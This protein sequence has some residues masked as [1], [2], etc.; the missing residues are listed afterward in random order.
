MI[1]PLAADDRAA[2]E[3]LWRAYM[4]FYE[5]AVSAEVYDAQWTRLMK[6]H[7]VAGRIASMDGEAI[8][9]VH[10]IVHPHG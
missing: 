9:L 7:P 5:T 2:W 3:R 1:R 6:G 8:G 10:Y 4:D